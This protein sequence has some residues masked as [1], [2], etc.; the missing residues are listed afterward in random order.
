MG[1]SEGKLYL[2]EQGVL[3]IDRYKDIKRGDTLEV[4]LDEDSGWF[5]VCVD[6]DENGD[7]CLYGGVECSV[8]LTNVIGLTARMVR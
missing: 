5:T 4:Q 1:K 7:W 2:N 3:C 8:R 6:K